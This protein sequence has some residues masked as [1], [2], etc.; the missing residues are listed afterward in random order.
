M[1][2]HTQANGV[3]IEV[4]RAVA[5]GAN[6][7]ARGR[8]TKAGTEVLRAGTRLGFAE[9]SIAAEFGHAQVAVYARPRVSILSTGDEVVPVGQT[10][11][12]FQIRNSNSLAAQVTRAGGIPVPWGAVADD[13]E[14]LRAKVLDGLGADALVLS[15][16]VS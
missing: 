15:G 16:G 14:K 2:E 8:E 7:V 4:Q 6:V 11:G 13:S 3:Q 12:P 1:I 5:A 10:P 9:V